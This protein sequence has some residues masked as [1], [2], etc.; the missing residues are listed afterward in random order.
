[1]GSNKEAKEGLAA[2]GEKVNGAQEETSMKANT[3]A[4]TY[5]WPEQRESGE[6]TDGRKISQ[7]CLLCLWGPKFQ[8]EVRHV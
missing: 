6:S 7:R 3:S 4:Q 2:S 8:K 1:M 5:T